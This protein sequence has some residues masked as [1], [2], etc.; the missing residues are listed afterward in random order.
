[1]KAVRTSFLILMLA[2]ALALAACSGKAPE[3]PRTEAA[4]AVEKI[5]VARLSDLPAHAYPVDGTVTELLADDV[6]FAKFASQVRLD[7]EDV[8]ARYEIDDAAT[9]QGYHGA[10]ANIALLE[11]RW[12]DVLGHL[13]HVRAL[14]DKE[15]ARLTSGLVGSCLVKARQQVGDDAPVAAVRPVFVRELTAQVDAL[16]WDI[17]QDNLQ[18]NRGRLQM[19]NPN[20]LAG[21]VQMQFDPVVVKSGELSGDMARALIGVKLAQSV[22]MPLRDDVIA[23]YGDYI[24]RHQQEK[25]NIWPDREV[26]LPAGE[27]HAP[28]VIG[29]WD[30]GVDAAVYETAMFTNPEETVDGRDDDG[31]GFVDDVHGIAWDL[32]CVPSTSLL[33]PTGAMTGRVDEA[34]GYIKGVMDLQASIDSDEATALRQHLGELPPE[35]VQDFMES[36]SFYGL[37]AHGTHVAG[38]AA[39]GNPYARIL[40]ARITF[41]FRTPPAPMTHEVARAWADAYRRTARYFADHGVRTVNMSWGWTFKEIESGLEANGIGA[42]PAERAQLAGEML[43]IL[44]TGL[45]GALESTPGILYVCAA[46]ND[47]NDVEFDRVIPSSWDLPNLLVVGAVDQAGDPTDFTSGGET[48]QVYANGFEVESFVPGGTRLAMSGTSMASPQVCNLAGKL[49][50]VRPE[51][52]PAEAAQLIREGADPHPTDPHIRLMNPRRTLELAAR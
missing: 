7:L 32:D 46:G 31:N 13:D 44:E 30:S 22:V 26:A 52:T 24:A 15:A 39:A 45:K 12:D 51:L 9:L 43:D 34:R 19:L 50:A 1:M 40:A 29:I 11:G 41:D 49:F 16:P 23:V 36:L 14:E 33:H 27:D 38:I 35:Q 2:G 5:Q 8:L 25:V 6:A 42:T 47:D 4:P 28:V 20:L 21:M 10:L 37:Y 48:V 17:V 18:A 3:S